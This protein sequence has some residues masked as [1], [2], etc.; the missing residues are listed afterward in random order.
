MISCFHEPRFNVERET[1]PCI[2]YIRKFNKIITEVREIIWGE[3]DGRNG[4]RRE[5]V[6]EEKTIRG[7]EGLKD[8]NTRGLELEGCRWWRGRG[9]WGLKCV[10][11]CFSRK[12]NNYNHGNVERP[13]YVCRESSS[14]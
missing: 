14:T 4:K 10:Q 5:E 2:Y 3:G 1:V 9:G 7:S 11:C 8:S 12:I 6:C 13:M